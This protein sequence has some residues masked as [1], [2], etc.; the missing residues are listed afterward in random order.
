MSKKAQAA[1]E[2]LSTYGWAMVMIVLLASAITYYA[3]DVGQQAP[4]TCKI[5]DATCSAYA[6]TEKQDYSGSL[7]FNNTIYNGVYG[8]IEF[9]ILSPESDTIEITNVDVNYDETELLVAC[10]SL[11]IVGSGRK[12]EL[13]CNACRDGG[14]NDCIDFLGSKDK[15]KLEV[16]V[17]YTLEGKMF[18]KH[19]KGEIITA[20]ANINAYT[21][22][23]NDGIDNDNDHDGFDSSDA[24]CVCTPEELEGTYEVEVGA[25]IIS[26]YCNNNRD[27]ANNLIC[28]N[29]ACKVDFQNNCDNDNDCASGLT[30]DDIQGICLR[31]LFESCTQSSECAVGMICGDQL[32][33]LGD[34]FY[35]CSD[36]SYCANN[37]ICDIDHHCKVNL[38]GDCDSFGPPQCKSGTVC[39]NNECLGIEGYNPCNPEAPHPGDCISSLSCINETCTVDNSC[40]INSDCTIE[41][42][43]CINGD[44]VQESGL[45]GECDDE[46]DCKEVLL[47][48]NL[49][50]NKCLGELTYS[51]CSG[52]DNNCNASLICPENTCIDPDATPGWCE[53]ETM[54]WDN[55]NSYC[56]VY[57]SSKSGKSCD[58]SC[59]K[60][61]TE[62]SCVEENWNDP[63]CVILNNFV[64][65]D[66]CNEGSS[67][68][69]P[70]YEKENKKGYYRGI[71]SQDCD[72]T[73]NKLT[74]LCVC[75]EEQGFGG[76]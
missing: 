74:R 25:C 72:A 51:P 47:T 57:D 11:P 1:M 48:C 66:S 49:D 24:S 64:D 12:I 39:E 9:D 68:S 75:E 69:Y 44:C 34:V 6:I 17:S 32:R 36:D 10:D 5:G 70:G 29:N 67:I 76:I 62:L 21:L 33:C 52:N 4:D 3:F 40:V 46:E 42:E 31:E 23:C 22:E 58:Y 63:G 13:R 43:T 41:G 15:D 27:C 18:T 14:S 60:Q 65:W 53:E 37:L 19:I 28:D 73:K 8:R 7:T 54:Y 2:F 26:N 38:H 56:W 16:D 45:G 50:Y 71:G 30:C 55:I 59:S 35:T 61:E 20:V